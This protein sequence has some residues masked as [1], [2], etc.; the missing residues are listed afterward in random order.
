MPV[1]SDHVE[2]ERRPKLGGGGPGKIPHRRGHGGGDD[3]DKGRDPKS[4][5]S[6]SK[7]RRY[8][9][10]MAACIATVT[11][12]FVGLT[13]A[14]L[15]RQNTHHWDPQAKAEVYDWKPIPLPYRQLWINTLVLLLSSVA[16]EMARRQ[17]TKKTE[18]AQ[19]GILPPR[20][21]G[22]LPWLGITVLLGTA[23]LAGQVL[24]WNLLRYQGLYLRANPSSSF[25]YLLTG[26]HA[27]HLAGGLFA[28]LCAAGG[29]WLHLRFESQTIAVEVTAWYWH[30][31][32]ILW[33]GIFA[34]L[35]FAD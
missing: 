11:V 20:S 26:L 14:Y 17:M 31:M 15:I 27:V 12:L 4:R 33:M 9:I 25:F 10:G 7:M 24:V 2:K 19:M 16:L 35:Y 5:D 1:V 32:G 13:T 23:F 6:N 29:R 18:F 3:G 22:E 30:F 34:L 8:R 21:R 28:L